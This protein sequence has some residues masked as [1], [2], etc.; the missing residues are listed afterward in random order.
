MHPTSGITICHG[1]VPAEILD[2]AG[3]EK[4]R[5]FPGDWVRK[6]A[7]QREMFSGETK[8][9]VRK[10]FFRE[11][12]SFFYATHSFL[13]F[14]PEEFNTHIRHFKEDARVINSKNPYVHSVVFPVHCKIFVRYVEMRK[15]NGKKSRRKTPSEDSANLTP[16]QTFLKDHYDTTYKERHRKLSTYGEADIINSHQL[17]P[18]VT[19]PPTELL[20]KVERVIDLGFQNPKSLRYIDF[21][22][23]NTES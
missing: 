18:F 10:R 20:E 9:R 23:A 22:S 19:N 6:R 14:C 1:Y 11:T 4:L 2:G 21:Y 13:F 12:V 16:T 3:I 8:A 15:W 5:A 7:P 17:F